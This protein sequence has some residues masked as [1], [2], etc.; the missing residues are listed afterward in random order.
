MFT[1]FIFYKNLNDHTM[2]IGFP[3]MFDPDNIIKL[4]NREKAMKEYSLDY[5]IETLKNGEQRQKGMAF[6]Y[7]L[8]LIENK[9]IICVFILGVF[10]IMISWLLYRNSTKSA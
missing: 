3:H 8:N 10:L 7:E 5:W 2:S 4:R 1:G 6:Y 9:A